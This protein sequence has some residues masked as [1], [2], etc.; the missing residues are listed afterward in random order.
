MKMAKVKLNKTVTHKVTE[1]KFGDLTS[2]ELKDTF[3]D[4]RIAS[5]FME[6]QLPYWYPEL[7]RVTGQKDHDHIDNTGRLFDQKTF[8]ARGVTCL[9]SN[10]QGKGRT[11]NEE[12]AYEKANKLI[13][14]ITD[15]NDFPNINVRF[16]EG[17]DLINNYPQLKVKFTQREEFLWPNQMNGQV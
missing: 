17:K 2:E 3:Q 14:I 12:A 5:W 4:G 16:V 1:F 13:Y 6:Q 7:T 11:F 9:P 15:V 10:Q 8:T